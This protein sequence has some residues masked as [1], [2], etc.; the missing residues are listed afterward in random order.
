MYICLHHQNELVYSSI[1][2]FTFTANNG[3]QFVAQDTCA[4]SIRVVIV[5]VPLGIVT[6][7]VIRDG[8]GVILLLTSTLTRF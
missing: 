8:E 2:F 1:N 6:L 7:F 4:F 5:V 3:L